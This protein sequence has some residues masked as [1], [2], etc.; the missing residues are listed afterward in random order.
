MR[1]FDQIYKKYVITE[2]LQLTRLKELI[3]INQEDVLQ[4][5]IE[6]FSR[7]ARWAVVSIFDE[8]NAALKNQG[9]LTINLDD[10]F[11]D[12]LNKKLE[13]EAIISKYDFV[14]EF[15]K[16]FEKLID[17]KDYQAII[18]KLDSKYKRYWVN[19]ELNFSKNV[20]PSRWMRN[21]LSRINAAE[22]TENDIQIITKQDFASFNRKERAMYDY[23]I[24]L[25]TNKPIAILQFDEHG[26]IWSVEKASTYNIGKDPKMSYILDIADELIAIKSDVM[27]DTFKKM[28]TRWENTRYAKLDQM[29]TDE[30]NAHEQEAAASKLKQRQVDLTHKRTEN[31]FK[32]N[33]KLELDRAASVGKQARELLNNEDIFA[34]ESPLSTEFLKFIT[35]Y[36]EAKEKMVNYRWYDENSANQLARK[37][38]SV[39]NQL[40]EKINQ[41][42][43]D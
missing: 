2:S 13:A 20:K 41:L 29:S 23:V 22:L 39:T 18:D 12:F 7:E 9:I 43:E 34:S 8:L 1:K 4:E 42:E 19:S 10:C 28:N 40:E 31:S 3:D 15:L 21:L 6:D 24:A 25:K 17:P 36:R 16:L 26:R 32:S 14:I 5:K 35:V 30:R 33:L 37:L 38:A 27:S 11:T